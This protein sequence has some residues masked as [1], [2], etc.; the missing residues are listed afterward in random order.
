MDYKISVIIPVYNVEKYLSQCLD[1]II[2]QSLKEI[3]IICINDG[4]TDS[5]KEVLER[6]R[7]ADSR[8]IVVNKAN[9]GYGAACNTGIRLA[10]G[11]YISI[12]ESDDF[13]DKNML[14][15]LYNLAQKHDVDIVKSAFYEYKDD[16]PENIYKINWSEQ[17]N[18]PQT[19]FRIND[20]SQLMYFHPSIWSCIYRKSFLDKNNIKFVEAKG[21]GWVD[22]PFQIQTLCLAKRIFY[23]DNAYY[24]YRLTNPSSSSNIVNISNPF[25]RSDEI[26]DFLKSRKINDKN[27]FAHLYKREFSYIHIVLSGIT[28]ELFDFA[29]VKINKMIERMNKEVL[30]ENKFVNDYE[31][32]VYESCKSKNG[33][34]SLMNKIKEHTKSVAVVKL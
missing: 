8:V 18:M 24:Y 21:A 19:V 14:E 4:S 30:Y 17:Y 16:E 1:S 5:S 29:C 31:K 3:E 9:A 34:A 22:N 10:R 25:D 2:E 11:E 20:C 6:Y 7:N 32:W 27:L 23:T 26:H 15:D 12:I 33:I 28:E 13:I